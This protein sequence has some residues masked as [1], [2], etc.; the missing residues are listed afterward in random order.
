M[1]T[2][3]VSDPRCNT[4]IVAFDRPH[5]SMFEATKA[6]KGARAY[7]GGVVESIKCQVVDATFPVANTNGHIS[8]KRQYGCPGDSCS[9][10]ED[11]FYSG[12]VKCSSGKCKRE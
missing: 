2:I 1:L 5:G 10:F 12:G 9:A 7:V 3:H 4:E 6:D 11:C 8:T